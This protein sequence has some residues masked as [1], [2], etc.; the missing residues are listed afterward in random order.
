LQ[1]Q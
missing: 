1:R